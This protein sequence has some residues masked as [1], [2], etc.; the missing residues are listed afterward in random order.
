MRRGGRLRAPLLAFAAMLAVMSGCSREPSGSSR[1]AAGARAPIVTISADQAVSPVP[2][3]R[4]PAV[5]VN[6]TNFKELKADAAEAL[7]EER[8]FGSAADAIPL[9]LALRRFAPDDAAV[10]AGMR[11][12]MTSLLGKGNE[13]LAA[14]DRDPL[15]LRR[16]HEVAAVARAVAPDDA[17]VV[18]YLARLDKSDQAQEANRLGEEALN[19][20]RLG[21]DGGDDTALAYFHEALE[22]R[23]GDQ[24]ANQGIAAVESAL[25]RRSEEHT[26]ELQSQSNLVCRLLL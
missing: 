25:I 8:L 23:P 3:W 22:L 18:A 20:G 9:Y 4:A 1:E 6:E 26:S 7:K 19:A 16:A 15:S 11:R 21:V 13:A 14:I 12:A 5:E 17:K 2:P 10:Q 24:R